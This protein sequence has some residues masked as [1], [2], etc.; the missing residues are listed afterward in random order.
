MNPFLRIVCLFSLVCGLLAG[1]APQPGTSPSDAGQQPASGEPQ[2]PALPFSEEDDSQAT[3]VD[4]IEDTPGELPA[5]GSITF[6]VDTA[7]QPAASSCPTAPGWSC[8]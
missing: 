6:T 5:L 4:D 8:R 1:C 2:N 7:H 3:F